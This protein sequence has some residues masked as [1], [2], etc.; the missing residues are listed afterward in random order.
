ML[1]LVVSVLN[2]VGK[3]QVVQSSDQNLV[4]VGVLGTSRL[5]AGKSVGTTWLCEAEIPNKSIKLRS[6]SRF[7]ISQP[8]CDFDQE[9]E[10][11]AAPSQESEASSQVASE[12]PSDPAPVSTL[13]NGLDF[14]AWGN[15]S[16]YISEDAKLVFG[17]AYRMLLA[18]PVESVK[19]ML[20]G[21][22]G[23]G[24]TTIAEQAAKFLGLEFLRFDCSTVRDPDAWYGTNEVR[25]HETS[26][27][28]ET[29]FVPTDLALTLAR[30]NCVI[31][32]DELNRVDPQLHNSI[33]PLLDDT[34]AI[35]VH[36]QRFTTGHNVI[37]VGTMNLGHKYTGILPLDEAVLNRFEFILEVGALPYDIE[38]E[39][40]TKR[41]AIDPSQADE[42]VRIATMLRD[43]DFNCSTRSSLRV[44]KMVAHGLT[45]RQAFEFSIV[46]R[47]P[48]DLE[49]APLRKAIV[50][51]LNIHLGT[52]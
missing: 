1:T 37:L 48:S 17:T 27:T 40:L 18:R 35:T 47:I 24:K 52:L 28:M 2:E 31:V 43:Q 23:F 51:L 44:A 41:Q 22:S 16:Y 3:Y 30:G 11:Q 5:V 4:S 25:K 12:A 39:V 19:I 10:A 32:L 46:R 49:N 6:V 29:R 34:Q 15:S 21:E 14:N 13:Q 26:D 8:V 38:C 36:G 45:L 7:D 42:I 9:S 50:D 20:T 33:L